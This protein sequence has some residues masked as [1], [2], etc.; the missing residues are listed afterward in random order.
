MKLKAIRTILTAAVF[1]LTLAASA[2]AQKRFAYAAN[3][4]SGE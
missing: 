4:E 2:N 3:S 1:A